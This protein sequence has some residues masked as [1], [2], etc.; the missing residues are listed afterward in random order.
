MIAVVGSQRFHV[1]AG[2]V[3]ETVPS[4]VTGGSRAA[5]LGR[6]AL[7]QI[8]IAYVGSRIPMPP[9]SIIIQLGVCVY[10]A[11]DILPQQPGCDHY[12]SLKTLCIRSQSSSSQ[13]VPGSRPSGP[14]I[15]RPRRT[16]QY[17]PGNFQQRSFAPPLWLAFGLLPATASGF[18]K[19]RLLLTTRSSAYA[20]SAVASAWPRAVAI[21]TTDL[22]STPRRLLTQ[23][24]CRCS[25]SRVPATGRKALPS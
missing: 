20:A 7:A 17:I 16:R 11:Y 9:S 1:E 18:K 21:P 5:H 8:K 22:S 2:R 3:I 4:S 14:E 23:R 6:R 24:G 13:A 12:T 25:P 10:N 15:G 19:A